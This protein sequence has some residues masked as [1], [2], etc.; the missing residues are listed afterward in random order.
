M[1]KRDENEDEGEEGENGEL[2]I[3]AIE[4][5]PHSVRQETGG[6]RLR[7]H[8]ARVNHT[9]KHLVTGQDPNS[10]TMD[11]AESVDMKRQSFP[12]LQA[13]VCQR[14]KFR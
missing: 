10:R 1:K 9:N 3:D 11:Q 2:S 12:E 8:R 7:R 6:S 5:M 14:R 4:S 13:R